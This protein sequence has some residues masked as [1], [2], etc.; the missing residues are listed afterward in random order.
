MHQPACAGSGFSF[1]CGVLLFQGRGCLDA[2]GTA[3][4]IVAKHKQPVQQ[5]DVN[6]P[7]LELKR[8]RYYLSRMQENGILT[9]RYN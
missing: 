6:T 2:L 4:R 3:A 7:Q 8:R 9:T 5:V 1:A